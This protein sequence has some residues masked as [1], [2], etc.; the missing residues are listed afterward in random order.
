MILKVKEEVEKAARDINANHAGANRNE[1]CRL[2]FNAGEAVKA[3]RF[4]EAIELAKKAQK[5]A[6]GSLDHTDN[7]KTEHK[8]LAILREYEFFNGFIRIKI[9]VQNEMQQTVNDVSLDISDHDE[10]IL[11]FDHHEPKTYTNTGSKIK[12]GNI[13][14][15]SDRTIALYLDPMICSKKGTHFNCQINYKD[16][17]GMPDTIMMETLK[18]NV[19]CPMFD[20]EQHI[21]IGRLKELVET[22]SAH[23]S[24]IFSMP[25]DMDIIKVLALCREVIQMHDV[26]HVRTFKTT[27]DIIYE[28][29]YYGKTKND[30]IDI[31][32]KT[33]VNK[34]ENIEVFIAAPDQKALTGLLAEIGRNLTE[35]TKSFAPIFNISIRDSI[36]QRSNLLSFCDLN[37][38]CTGNVVIE[39]SIIQRS[40]IN[41]IGGQ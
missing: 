33:S 17:Y 35:K 31:I 10:H 16:S 25:K 7:I 39:D 19:I 5:S 38:I 8:K 21:N 23:G 29:W 41:G 3:D 20:T 1:A 36:I 6:W 34:D 14:P 13:L 28:T 40:N 22:L 27:D 30:N 11:R 2:L 15:N 32:I 4:D 26:R 37:G 24:K 9:S 12:L 18:V